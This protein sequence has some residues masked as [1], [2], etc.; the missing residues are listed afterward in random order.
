MSRLTLEVVDGKAVYNGKTLAEWVPTAVT[1]IV[2][3]FDPLKIILFGSVA[4]GD[5][6]PDSDVDLLVVFSKIAGRRDEVAVEI[7]SALG[8]ERP[9]VDIFAADLDDIAERG[10]LPGTLRVALREGTVL[11]ARSA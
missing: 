3:R 2:E 5:D 9:P 6:G 8:R 10:D 11:H 4:R 1:R 7:M